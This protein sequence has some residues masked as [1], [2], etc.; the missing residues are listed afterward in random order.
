MYILNKKLFVEDQTYHSQY[1][2]LHYS[3]V[4]IDSLIDSL[5]IADWKQVKLDPCL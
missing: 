2:A 1:Y 4:I 5:Q 3:G